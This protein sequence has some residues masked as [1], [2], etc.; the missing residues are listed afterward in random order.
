MGLCYYCGVEVEEPYRCPHCNLTFCEEHSSQKDHNC[1][2]LSQQLS[3]VASKPQTK[4][5]HYVES[6]RA[7]P[8][9]RT[10]RKRTKKQQSFLG[11]GV[12][13]R[14]VVLV[15]LIVFISLMSIMMLNQWEPEPDEPNIG[16][17]FPISVET[18][19]QQEFVVELINKERVKQDLTSLAY[20]N[21]SVPQRYAEEMLE[22]GVFKHNPDLPGNMGENIDL[23]ALGQDYNITSVLELMVH[24]QAQGD[25]DGT[26][27]QDN[28]LYESYT[29]V[30]VGVAYDDVT[31]YLVMNFE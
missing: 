21:N 23:F 29:T 27:N 3:D 17:K 26:G 4:T 8:R 2:A 19:E 13:K 18:L 28:I 31:L 22:T 25:D 10:P 11:V 15:A 6:E 12:T 14:K 24:E 20:S 1:I 7:Q 9:V 5:I 30:S 16:A